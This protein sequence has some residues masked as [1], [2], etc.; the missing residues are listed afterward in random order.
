MEETTN[1]HQTLGCHRDPGW[2]RS[3]SAWD[4]ERGTQLRGQSGEGRAERHRQRCQA[5]AAGLVL[6]DCSPLPSRLRTA[7]SWCPHGCPH[8]NSGVTAISPF[9]TISPFPAISALPAISRGRFAHTKECQPQGRPGPP[10]LCVSYTHLSLNNNNNTYH[11]SL[12]TQLSVTVVP[13]AAQCL[14]P[15]EDTPP[16][17]SNLPFPKG[18][19]HQMSQR[20]NVPRGCENK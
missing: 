2:Q 15:M 20:K 1:A 9:P 17:T 12:N 11:L 16:C 19:E 10:P 7:L 8:G 18:G 3:H 4:Q 5:R 14:A 13:G 6:P